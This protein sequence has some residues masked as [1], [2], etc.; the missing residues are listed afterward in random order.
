MCACSPEGQRY[1]GLHQKRREASREREGIVPL[2]SEFVRTR[3]EY[4][5]QVQGSKLRK[6]VELLDRTQRRDMKMVRGLEHLSYEDR[7]KEL[8]LFSLEKRRLWGELTVVF[9]YLKGIYK[10]EGDQLFMW[11]DSD[12]T[13][14]V[15]LK[16]KEGRFRLDV[17]RKAFFSERV[18]RCWNRLPREVVDALSLEVFKARLDGALSNLI[19]Y[20]V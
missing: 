11:V 3:L 12:R 19:Y 1:P 16:L 4:C 6:D 13:R 18:V 7:L 15:V 2:Y 5:V 9:Q 10:H 8:G 14:G 20:L 17:R